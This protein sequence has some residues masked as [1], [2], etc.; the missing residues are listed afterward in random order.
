[1]TEQSVTPT[2]LTT[3][4]QNGLAELETVIDNGLQTFVIFCERA[5]AESFNAKSASVT[6]FTP[7]PMPDFGINSSAFRLA[8][9]AV[10]AAWF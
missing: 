8:R 6:D 4:E 5:L 1:M 7:L 3:I 9:K 10:S 2:T